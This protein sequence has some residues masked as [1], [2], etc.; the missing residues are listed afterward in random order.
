M[1]MGTVLHLLRW[2]IAAGSVL[3]HLDELAPAELVVTDIDELSAK[4]GLR[5]D[6]AADSKKTKPVM[7]RCGRFSANQSLLP[8]GAAAEPPAKESKKAAANDL[9]LAELVVMKWELLS[10]KLRHLILDEAVVMENEVLPA[11]YTSQTDETA[12]EPSA[13]DSKEANVL[14]LTCRYAMASNEEMGIKSLNARQ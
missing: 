14:T 7:M 6:D 4:P 9:A 13:T 12:A 3:R 2:R 8:G 1:A 10:A 5:Q 11:E